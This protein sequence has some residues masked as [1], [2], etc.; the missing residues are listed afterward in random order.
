MIDI[1]AHLLVPNTQKPQLWPAINL[2]TLFSAELNRSNN[3]RR[4]RDDG[5]GLIV[6]EIELRR[7]VTQRFPQNWQ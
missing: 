2:K 5:T 7:Y 1:P 6:I 3:R 4:R